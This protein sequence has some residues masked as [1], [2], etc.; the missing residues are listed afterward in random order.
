M[1]VEYCH[2]KDTDMFQV[3]THQVTRNNLWNPW[4]RCIHIYCFVSRA[5]FYFPHLQSKPD[6]LRFKTI[7]VEERQQTFYII[8][9]VINRL[10]FLDNTVIIKKLL[11]GSVE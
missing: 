1:V 3:K 7:H 4:R 2:D 5:L 10:A 11:L 8:E 9:G 6:Y